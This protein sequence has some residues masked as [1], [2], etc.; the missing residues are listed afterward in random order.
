MAADYPIPLDLI[1]MMI[2]SSV[3]KDYIALARV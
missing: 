3:L 2:V 1:R